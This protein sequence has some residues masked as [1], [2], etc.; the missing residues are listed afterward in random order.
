MRRERDIASLRRQVVLLSCGLLVAGGFV[1][2][3]GQRFQAVRYGYSSEQL[4]E[5]RARLLAE[6]DRLM[7]ELN[8][9]TAPG[10]LE[11]A[12]RGIGMQPARASQIGDGR[13]R[14]AQQPPHP[15]VVGAGF[16]VVRQR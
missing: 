5:E 16:G 7:L 11:L 3:V 15:S 10:A 2:A 6:R 8:E 13:A 1:L 9:V 12:A 4:R 14:A